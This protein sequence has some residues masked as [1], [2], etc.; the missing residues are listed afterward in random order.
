MGG[1]AV[2]GTQWTV[3]AMVAQT[4]G[5]PL[6]VGVRAKNINGE[7]RAD[8]MQENANQQGKYQKFLPGAYALGEILE[9]N[10][11]QNY[12]LIGS[13]AKFGGSHHYFRQHGHYEI[14][15]YVYAQE[16][17]YID[18]DY[19]VFWGYEDKKLYAFAK[20]EINKIAQKNQPFNYTIVTIDTHYPDGYLDESCPKN[21]QRQYDNVYRCASLMLGDFI[22]WAKQQSWY[23][24]TTIIISGDHLGMQY[25]YYEEWIG[26]RAYERTIYNAFINAALAPANTQ[27]RQFTSLDMYPTTL[28]ALGAKIDGERLGLGV[29]LFSGQKTLLE[30]F[31]GNI[32]KLDEEIAKRNHIY[33]DQIRR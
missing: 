27:N 8:G 21:H 17:R 4:A 7:L 32:K 28:A 3:A 5:V 24:N 19:K 14:H 22:A 9:K 25:P 2:S 10:G 6:R 26:N 15:D 18:K 31:N 33:D 20:S 13:D 11:Y 1:R 16:K 23:E 12:L 29:N 30:R